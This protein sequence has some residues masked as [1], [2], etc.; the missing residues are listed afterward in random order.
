M[1]IPGELSLFS[2][3]LFCKDCGHRISVSWKSAK[4]HE[5]GKCGVCNY[6]K[7]Y[8]KYEV[9]TPHYINYDEFESQMLDY[10]IKVVKKRLEVLDTPRLR[11]GNYKNLANKRI[12]KGKQL[13][14][15]KKI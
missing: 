2:K 6:Y 10:I 4:Y 11:K 8:S 15:L 13:E 1:R 5:K 9:C 3:K 12:E 7:K 14:R